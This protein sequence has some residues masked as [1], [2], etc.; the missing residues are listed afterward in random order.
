MLEFRNDLLRDH[1][2]RTELV[3]NLCD[4]MSTPS[5]WGEQQQQ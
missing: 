3:G 5:V 4:V 1:E 2:W